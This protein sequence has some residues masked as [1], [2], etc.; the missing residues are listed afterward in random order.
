MMLKNQSGYQEF[1]LKTDAGGKIET[2]AAFTVYI[3]WDW[4]IVCFAEKDV[5]FSPERAATY[6]PRAAPGQRPG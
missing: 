4:L 5:V 2:M 6:Q 1:D 3:K